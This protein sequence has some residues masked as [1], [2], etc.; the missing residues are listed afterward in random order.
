MRK[1][2]ILQEQERRCYYRE[3][4]IIS[5]VVRLILRYMQA[6]HT[7]CKLPF[8]YRHM[9]MPHIWLPL[10]NFEQRSRDLNLGKQYL[11]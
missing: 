6:V 5:K 11:C 3:V 8:H 10:Q 9:F 1:I 4:D 7:C 2:G